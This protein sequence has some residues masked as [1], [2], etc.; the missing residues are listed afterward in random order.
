MAKASRR[1]RRNEPHG[2]GAACYFL[3]FLPF[4]DFLLFFAISASL[5]PSVACTH[6][7]T[8]VADRWR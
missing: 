1:P 2:S 7:K 5:P 3:P 8:V 4:F 6:G